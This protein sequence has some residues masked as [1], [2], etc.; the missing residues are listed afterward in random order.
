[1]DHDGALLVD[2]VWPRERWVR[3]TVG[4]GSVAPLGQTVDYI[5]LRS[6]TSG[7]YHFFLDNVEIRRADGSLKTVIW[8]S[9]SDSLRPFYRYDGVRHSRWQSV[10]AVDGFPFTDLSLRSVECA[11]RCQDSRASGLVE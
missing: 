1:V 11:H 3:T 2:T 7:T 8:A 9:G 6:P 4:I 10:S 5:A